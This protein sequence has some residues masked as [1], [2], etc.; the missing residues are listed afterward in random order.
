MGTF[1][2]LLLE[3]DDFLLLVDKLVLNGSLSVILHPSLIEAILV[4]IL[5]GVTAGLA[6]LFGL[7]LVVLDALFILLDQCLKVCLR[8]AA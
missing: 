1:D 2:C 5:E 7:L 4:L 6:F 8:L 3:C